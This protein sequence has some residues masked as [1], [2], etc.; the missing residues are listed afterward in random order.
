MIH[1]CLDVGSIVESAGAVG[2]GVEIGLEAGVGVAVES[3][4]KL[5]RDEN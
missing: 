2:F 4:V 1:R 5:A 3:G